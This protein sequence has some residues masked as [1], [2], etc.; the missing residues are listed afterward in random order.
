[1]KY[2]TCI[3]TCLALSSSIALAVES[4]Y[5]QQTN[6]FVY[7]TNEASKQSLDAIL[8]KFSIQYQYTNTLS[9]ND[10]SN[11]YIITG[12]ASRLNLSTMPKYYIIYQT[13]SYSGDQLPILSNAIAVWDQHAGNINHY[14]NHVKHYY[15]VPNENYEFLD[16]VILPCFLPLHALNH[17]KNILVYSKRGSD[18]SEH[19][20]ALYCHCMFQ[21]PTIIVEAGVRWG[22]GSTIPLYHANE[23]S[24]AYLLG[25]DINNCA[26]IYKTF[27]NSRFIQMSDLDFLNLFPSLNLAKNTIDF[28][29]I[30]T[31]HL[32]DHTISEIMMFEK[33][34]SVKGA[35]G[36]HDTNPVPGDPT[37]ARDAFMDYFG[38]TFDVNHYFS[39]IVTKNNHYWR[40]IH[41]P[42]NNGMS[43]S[44]RLAHV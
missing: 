3:V 38:L 24:G 15:H 5:Q 13:G 14:R 34:L 2:F 43:I 16:P 18:I 21:N 42:Y 36:F 44:Q 20:A 32:Y 6:I 19:L 41:Y 4:Q 29:F 33:M 12:T 7:A 35:I 31:T 17:Y 11:L 9:P 10:S 30:D 26:D 28:V 8:Q 37:G 40:I 39:G 23:A 22:D 27:K 25:L 1:M